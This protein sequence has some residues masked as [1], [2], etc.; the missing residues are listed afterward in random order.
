MSQN[1]ME[2]STLREAI[3]SLPINNPYRQSVEVWLQ[4]FKK[5]IHNTQNKNA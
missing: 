5:R 3:Q 4:R 2:E 1:T